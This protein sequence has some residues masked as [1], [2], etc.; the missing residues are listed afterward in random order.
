LATASTDGT[1]GLYPEDLAIQ[2]AKEDAILNLLRERMT[3]ADR[4]TFDYLRT[5]AD[6][7]QQ[8]LAQAEA[9]LSDTTAKIRALVFKYLGI[10]TTTTSPTISTISTTST[11]STT[12]TSIAASSN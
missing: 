9:E 6:Q 4:V 7:Q 2:K 11:V 5:L 1:D 8:A 10:A 12:S 3:E